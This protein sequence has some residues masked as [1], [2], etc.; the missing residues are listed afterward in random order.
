MEAIS[1]RSALTDC[2]PFWRTFPLA[3]DAA[4]PSGVFGP[5]EP[6]QGRLASAA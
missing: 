2:R 3:A 5:V 6:F 1:A 4:L